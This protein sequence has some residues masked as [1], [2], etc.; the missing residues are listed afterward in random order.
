MKKQLAATQAAL[1]KLASGSTPPAT[2]SPSPSPFTSK[3]RG[4]SYNYSELTPAFTDIDSVAWTYNWDQLPLKGVDTAPEFVPMLWGPT[5][6][7]TWSANAKQC[8]KS[9]SKYLLGYV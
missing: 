4:L 7:S 9:G 6:A 8:I 5:H 1:K 2:G 3:K